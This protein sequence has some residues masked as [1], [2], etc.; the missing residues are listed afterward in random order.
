[1]ERRPS[2]ATTPTR[3]AYGSTGTIATEIQS[4]LKIRQSTELQHKKS[5]YIRSSQHPNLISNMY[6]ME[7]T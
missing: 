1:M 4:R 7:F 3:N 6:E 5:R 2:H